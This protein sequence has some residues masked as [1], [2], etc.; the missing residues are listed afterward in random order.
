[1]SVLSTLIIIIIADLELLSNTVVC[2]KQHIVNQRSKHATQKLI[3]CIVYRVNI[4]DFKNN[5]ILMHD[6][7]VM[8]L[9]FQLSIVI[10]HEFM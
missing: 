6:T 5:N 8:I 10:L 9:N 3:S 1:M 7:D 2:I 4:Q